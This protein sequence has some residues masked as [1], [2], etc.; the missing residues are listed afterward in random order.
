MSTPATRAERLITH[1]ADGGGLARG[2]L[3]A[4]R[5][6]ERR[7]ARLV[8]LAA[9]ADRPELIE[10]V[11]K[12]AR[13]EGVPVVDKHDRATLGRWA[14]IERPAAVLAITSLADREAF[15]TEVLA[16]VPGVGATLGGLQALARASGGAGAADA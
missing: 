12:L 2:V 1:A 14:K 7:E 4:V 15:L 11:R 5:A 6:L 8:F 10:T 3:E 13:D 16:E 9:D